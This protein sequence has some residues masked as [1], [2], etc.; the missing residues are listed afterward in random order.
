[1]AL[2]DRAH[3]GQAQPGS[4][5]RA[6]VAG[7]AQLP[8]DEPHLPLG[9][10]DPRVGD[11][12]RH[13]AALLPAAHLDRPAGGGVLGRVGHDVVDGRVEE[14]AV[15]AHVR[16]GPGDRRQVEA[17]AHGGP[18]PGGLLDD[19]G[20]GVLDRLGQVDVLQV[21]GRRLELGELAQV[22]Q[23]PAHPA[24]LGVDDLEVDGDGGGRALRGVGDGGA[25]RRQRVLELMVEAPQE[26]TV[27]HARLLLDLEAQPPERGVPTTAA[28]GHGQGD[29]EDDGQDLADHQ[30]GRGRHPQAQAAPQQVAH[31]GEHDRDAEG[32]DPPRQGAAGRPARVRGRSS[33]TRPTHAWTSARKRYPPAETVSM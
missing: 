14:V 23:Q 19:G 24:G 20:H 7:A 18:A 28:D 33:R 32:D 1:M 30:R 26:L 21:E 3:Q 15:A 5:Q 31:H 8:E 2:R 6:G 25:H 16:Q 10:A 13:R 12:D 27:L 9:H 29:Q 17:Y 22:G 4:G 11:L